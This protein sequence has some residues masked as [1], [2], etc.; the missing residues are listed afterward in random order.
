[1]KQ[2]VLPNSNI[3]L[4]DGSVVTLARFPDMKWVVHY[5]WYT[6]KGSQKCEWYFS[7]IPE[8]ITIPICDADLKTLRIVSGSCDCN[9]SSGTGYNDATCHHPKQPKPKHSFTPEDRWELERAALSVNTIAERDL[10]MHSGLLPD[11]KLVR[12]SECPDG[13]TRYFAWNQATQFWDEEVFGTG[14]GYTREEADATF[15]TKAYVIE[16]VTSQVS[17][18]DI[19]SKVN[20]AI[21]DADI[22]SVIQ[23]IVKEDETVKTEIQGVVQTIIDANVENLTQ[24]LDTLGDKVDSIVASSGW[25]PLPEII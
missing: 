15:A 3:C 14:G 4:V 20:K 10:L 25:E 17:A 9:C 12:V 5:G 11:G 22:P 2:L 7:S 19:D 23:T 8:Q 21:E 24:E 16:E 1:M 6:Y 18:I 13:K